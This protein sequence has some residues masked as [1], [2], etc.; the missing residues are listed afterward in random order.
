MGGYNSGR[1]GWRRKE[2]SQ[3]SVDIRWMKRKG[4]LYN[5][6][7]G[8]LR[9]SCRGEETGSIG[10]RVT[11][12]AINLIYK[13]REHGGEW[14][15]VEAAIQLIYTSCNYGGKRVWMR[16]PNCWRRCGKVYLTGKRPACRKCYDLAY[17]SEAETQLDRSMR[18]ARTA[19]TKLGYDEGDLSVWPSKPKGMHWKTYERHMRVIKQADDFFNREAM[20]RFNMVF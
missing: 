3:H 10:Y 13:H 20:Q 1:S 9:W 15:P 7:A 8:S 11:A 17:Y 16:C 18:R 5:G 4:W 2:G 12:D 14:E 6:C 19:Q